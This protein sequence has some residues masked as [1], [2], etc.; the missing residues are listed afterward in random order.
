MRN[1]VDIFRRAKEQEGSVLIL[2]REVEIIKTKKR[3]V[4]LNDIL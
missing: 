4:V 3:R 1:F 2:P